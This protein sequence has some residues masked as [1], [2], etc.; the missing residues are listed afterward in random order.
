MLLDCDVTVF[1]LFPNFNYYF[2]MRLWMLSFLSIPLVFKLISDSFPDEI[3]KIIEKSVYV[4]YSILGILF[5]TINLNFVNENIYVVIYMTFA[6]IFY[7]FF[8][9]AKA[10]YRKRK[11]SIQHI[12]SFSIM[13]LFFLNDLIYVT[14]QSTSG[15]LSQIGVCFYIIVQSVIISMKF[16]NSQKK[17]ADLKDELVIV[18]QNLEATIDLRTKELR[19]TNES[20]EILIRQKDFLISTISHDLKNS[21]NILLNLSTLLAKNTDLDEKLKVDLADRLYDTS[22]KGFQVLEN[23][24]GWARL[25]ISNKTE[26]RDI[27]YL[28][29]YIDETIKLF[30]DQIEEKSLK[31][32]VQIDDSLQFHCDE[33]HLNAILRNLLSNSVKFSSKGGVITFRNELKE[34]KVI[35]TVRDEGIGIPEAISES[36]FECNTTKKRFGTLGEE[37]T[38]LGLVIVKELVESNNGVI[39][40]YSKPGEFTEFIISFPA[41]GK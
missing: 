9:L 27:T 29:F 17:I 37:G 34:G 15:Y 39:S 31:T 21:F 38:G 3:N 19:S 28:S 16:A 32:I 26:T 22:L 35:I 14:N 2:G 11:Y 7:M 1:H 5:M 25:Q 8:I 10:V 4:I 36:I 13:I 6:Y 20:L 40:C 12:V 33:S 18:N 41:N 23:V 24:L 30:S